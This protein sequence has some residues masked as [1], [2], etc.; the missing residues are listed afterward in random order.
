MPQEWFYCLFWGTGLG[1]EGLGASLSLGLQRALQD[2][3]MRSLAALRR[4]VGD[5][6]DIK[7]VLMCV[8]KYLK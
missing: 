3:G 8:L 4:C 7:A 2:I 5:G 6:P 1:G